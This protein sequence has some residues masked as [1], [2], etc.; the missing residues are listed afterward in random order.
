MNRHEL[1]A[2]R[3]AW[4]T[5]AGWYRNPA[6]RKACWLWQFDDRHHDCGGRLEGMHLI[7]R[8]RLRNRLYGVESEILE[9]IQWDPRNAA[10]GCTYHHR[11]FD[12]HATPPLRVPI[13][14]LPRQALDFIV[15]RG[16]ESDA[17]AKFTG[18]VGLALALPKSSASTGIV[19]LA[20]EQSGLIAAGQPS[21]W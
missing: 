3:S 4:I 1:N 2:L 7:S 12:S 13:H 10:I 17:E 6:G 21:A 20:R 5:N 9:L 11:R 15:E 18:N 16:L 8:Q 14:G 19:P